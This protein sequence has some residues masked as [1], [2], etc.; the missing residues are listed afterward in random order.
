MEL[1]FATNNKNK[2]KEIRK[3][4]GESFTIYSLEDKNI[5]EEIPETHETIEENAIEK[6]EYIYNKYSIACFADDTG[7]EIKALNGE[8]GVYSARYAGEHC[9]FMDN[10]NKVL[11]NMQGKE[12]RKACFRTI[13]AFVSEKGTFTY[14]GKVDGEITNEPRGKDGFGYDPIFLPEESGLT[15][16]EMSMDDKNKISHRARA[17][18]N[19][20]DNIK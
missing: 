3:A 20:V 5:S 6:A 4:F 1:L 8:P 7:L 18:R 19:F 16:A 15:F 11:R 12:N 10:V 9:S 13:V 17:M 2:L 14:E